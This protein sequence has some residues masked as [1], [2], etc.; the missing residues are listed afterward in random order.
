[1]NI[2]PFLYIIIGFNAILILLVIIFGII[3]IYKG[4]TRV[5][6]FM[7]DKTIF[8]KRFIGRLKTDFIHIKG[9]G[10]FKIENDK[11]YRNIFGYS[12][13][14]SYNNPSPLTIDFNTL[15]VV[16]GFTPIDINNFYNSDLIHKLFKTENIEK[17]ILVLVIIILILALINIG[18]ILFKKPVSVELSNSVNNTLII[19]NAVI[20]AIKGI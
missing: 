2:S 7:P 11:I 13:Y 4:I 1:M 15:K 18:I 12:I 17:I 9:V 16:N 19:K 8:V 10:S 5:V 6:V 3:F 14:Y 20:E